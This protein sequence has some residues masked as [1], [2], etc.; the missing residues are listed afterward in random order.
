MNPKIFILFLIVLLATTWILVINPI[1]DEINISKIN[2]AERE[3][4][5]KVEKYDIRKL[6]F[7]EKQLSSFKEETTRMD[8]A[9][10]ASPLEEELMLEIEALVIRS[11]MSL[12]DLK[13]SSSKKRKSE[14]SASGIDIKINAGGNYDALKRFFLLIY[15]DLRIINTE[16]VIFSSL[17]DE[18]IRIYD[19]SIALTTYYY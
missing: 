1:F 18:E 6:Q 5:I 3:E 2:I 10:P 17:N 16:S 7:F 8:T 14:S 12:K 11:G 19:F 9:L 4:S 13:I 15:Q